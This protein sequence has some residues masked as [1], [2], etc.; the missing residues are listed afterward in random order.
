MGV[1]TARAVATR[2]KAGPSC[3]GKGQDQGKGG[4]S[5]SKGRGKG[6]DQGKGGRIPPDKSNEKNQQKSGG[7][8]NPTLGGTT[9]DHSGGQSSTG[10]TT[11]SQAQAQ[12]QGQQEQGA[13]RPNEDHAEESGSRKRSRIMRMVRK[14]CK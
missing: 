7:N 8:P 4:K 12:A 10:P 6:Q 5:G 11:R 14:L 1:I 9:P 2:A 3:R 13:K